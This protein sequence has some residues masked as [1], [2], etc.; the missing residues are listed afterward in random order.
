MCGCSP[1]VV[2]RYVNP[3]TG[4]ITE[5]QT[6]SAAERARRQYGGNYQAVQR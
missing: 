1:K 3:A 4:K 5:Y 6:A 2:Y